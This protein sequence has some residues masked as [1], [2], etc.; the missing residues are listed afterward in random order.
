MI[1]GK[2]LLI[3][4]AVVFLIIVFLFLP[5]KK[6][7]DKKL[8]LILDYGNNRKQ[9]FQLSTSEQRRIWSILQEVAA[10][11][12]ID[13]EATNELYPRKIDGLRDGTDNKHWTLYVN[14]TKQKLSSADVFV[15][16]PTE[17]VFRF[18]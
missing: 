15:E 17:V 4:V 1:I 3:I 12:K 14:G 8:T 18:E 2:K 16:P 10:V 7:E 6:G 13:L 11:S 5:V 9:T